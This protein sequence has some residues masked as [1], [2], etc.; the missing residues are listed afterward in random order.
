[1]S[2]IHSAEEAVAKLEAIFQK[3][4]ERDEALLAYIKQLAI[5]N[6]QLKRSLHKLR[7]NNAMKHNTTSSM[8]SKLTDALRE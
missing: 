7:T 3:H 2:T 8:H 6:E 1:M 4:N 5:E